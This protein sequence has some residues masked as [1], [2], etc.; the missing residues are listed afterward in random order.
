MI[1]KQRGFIRGV[2]DSV[3]QAVLV[4]VG[5]SFVIGFGIGWL[6]GGLY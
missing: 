5:I 4:V 3:L 1:T 2:G 6:F